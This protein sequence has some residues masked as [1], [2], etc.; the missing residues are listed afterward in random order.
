M[1]TVLVADDDADHRELLTHALRRLGHRVVATADAEAARRALGAGG[2][3]AVLL[4][5]RMP[6]ESGIDLCRRLRTD[7]VTAE[8]PIM[9]VSADVNGRRMLA[10]MDAGADDYL[11]KPYSRSELGA[12]VEA[13]LRR[14]SMSA[15]LPST[16]ANAAMLA[17]RAAL[18]APVPLAPAQTERTLPRTA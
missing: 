13:L 14:R 11:T 3:D 5:V 15:A 17:A 4:D 1:T 18:P 12:R 2:I 10:G 16:V 9:L 6:G 7:P 8:L